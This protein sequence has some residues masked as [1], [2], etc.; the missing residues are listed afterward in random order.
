LPADNSER[1][2]GR[3]PE[4]WKARRLPDVWFP[5]ADDAPR[6]AWLGWLCDMAAM[7]RAY[8]A[9]DRDR[10]EKALIAYNSEKEARR[11]NLPRAIFQ[12]LNGDGEVVGHLEVD[13]RDMFHWVKC[14]GDSLSHI[15]T[16]ANVVWETARAYLPDLAATFEE[17]SKNAHDIKRL[18]VAERE[19]RSLETHAAAA[20]EA[21]RRKAGED[22]PPGDTAKPPLRRRRRPPMNPKGRPLT[23]KQTEAVQIVG[24]CKGNYAEAARR[25]GKDRK[26][27]EQHY[28]AAMR[29]LGKIVLPKPKLRALPQD[30]R[31]QPNVSEDGRL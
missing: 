9:P 22:G 10:H 20:A 30:R 5:P 13:E 14:Y 12:K 23:A 26:T 6:L 29:K 3:T 4:Y 7:L 15:E 16:L 25:V 19:W 21:E 27:V 31:G 28:R 8:F 17:V 18:D 2:P 1:L 11:R 24:E